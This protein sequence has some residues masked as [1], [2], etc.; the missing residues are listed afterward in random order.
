MSETSRDTRRQQTAEKLFKIARA[1]DGEDGVRS[2]V[3]QI[4]EALECE[5]GEGRDDEARNEL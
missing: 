3:F 4:K 2:A 1:A 5:Y